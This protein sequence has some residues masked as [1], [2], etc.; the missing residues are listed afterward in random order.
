MIPAFRDANF[1]APFGDFAGYVA[2]FHLQDVVT[3][4]GPGGGRPMKS[5]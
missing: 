4:V 3:E 1:F 5:P 2:F